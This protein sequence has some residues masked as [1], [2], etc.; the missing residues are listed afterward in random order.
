MQGNNLFLDL[1]T[2]YTAYIIHF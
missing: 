1:Y 2:I